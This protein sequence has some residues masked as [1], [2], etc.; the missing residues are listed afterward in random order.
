MPRP[1]FSGQN[2]DQY[3]GD[4]TPASSAH[5]LAKERLAPSN[6]ATLL[7]RWIDDCPNCS[8]A[9]ISAPTAD[10]LSLANCDRKKADGRLAARD[11]RRH[12]YVAA[13]IGTYRVLFRWRRLCAWSGRRRRC[14]ALGRNGACLRLSGRHRTECGV[15]CASLRFPETGQVPLD[16][17]VVLS[18]IAQF[19]E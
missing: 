5:F 13:R 16:D 11:R 10:A 15:G 18:A 9:S 17:S 6:R 2:A 14:H 12:L 7:G 4:V 8:T 19:C 3:R 1:S